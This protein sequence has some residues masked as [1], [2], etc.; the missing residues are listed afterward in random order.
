VIPILLLLML[1][2]LM[3]ITSGTPGLAGGPE[4]A[5]GYL[6]LTAYFNGKLVNRIGLPKLTG[7]IIAGIVV[8]P[9]VLGLVQKTMTHDLKMVGDMA[10]ALLALQAGSELELAAI[11]PQLRTIRAMALYAVIG[12]MVVLGVLL[13]VISPLVPFLDRLPFTAMVAV[14]ATMGIAMSAQSPAVVMALIA[15]VRAD[16]VLTRTI[17]ATVVIADI[18]VIVLYG[19]ASAAATAVVAGQADIRAAIESIGWEVFGSLGVGLFIGVCLSRFLVSVGKGVG[20]FTILVCFVMAQ[21]G[22]AVHLDPLIILLTAGIYVGNFSK[23]D[24]HT[25]VQGLEAAALPVFLVFFALAGAKLDLQKLVAVALPVG[26]IVL[27]RATSFYT[28]A[29][30]AGARSDADPVIKKFAWFGILPQAGLALALAELVRRTFPA[31]GDEAF[32]LAVGVVATNEMIAPVLLRIA[33]LRSGEAGKRTT[34][35]FAEDH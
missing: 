13:V 23:A 25:L 8:G 3:H 4:L 19:I 29:R 1:G 7:Y 16:G 30:I 6:L 26:L 18:L 12:T 22:N 14:S 21:V 20:L 10:T 27:T 35:D 11:R 34:H 33:F 17:L 15:E 32:A 31:F 9:N 2:G 28:G 5:F 24:T